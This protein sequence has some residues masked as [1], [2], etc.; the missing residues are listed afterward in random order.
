MAGPDAR[1]ESCERMTLPMLFAVAL[2]MDGLFAGVAYGV[3]GIHIPKRSMGIIALCTMFCMGGSM[4][5]GTMARE[6]ISERTIQLLGAGILASLG[7]WQ[8]FQGWLEYMRRRATHEPRGVLR[9]RIQDVGIVVQILREPALA[10]TDASGRIDP[11][12]ALLLGIALGL[13]SFGAGFAAALLHLGGLVL[14]PIVAVAQVV[15][16]ATGLH[17]GRTYG[18]R[19]AQGKGLLLP[20]AILCLLALFQLK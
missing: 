17:L 18:S 2:S 12:E 10:D 20:G 9:L 19:L 7:V 4:L 13:D 8:M 14:V 5:L 15:C 11:K 16:T 3:R 6:L 1:G